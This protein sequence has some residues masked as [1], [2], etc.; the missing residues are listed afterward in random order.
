[1]LAGRMYAVILLALVAAPRDDFRTLMSGL[2]RQPSRADLERIARHPDAHLA[3]LAH[4]HKE[5][6]FVRERAISALGMFQTPEVAKELERLLHDRIPAVRGAAAAVLGRHFGPAF[7]DEVLAAL[8]PLLKD[9]NA[10]VR[11]QA[12]RG[13]S[14]VPKKEVIAEL[15]QR[16]AHERD[17]ALREIIFNRAIML[18]AAFK[19]QLIS[20]R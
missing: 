16:L 2:E 6:V 20:V 8:R 18:E 19:Q 15:T 1:M 3:E 10:T 17:P 7:P 14:Q 13:L 4:D 5:H 12:V 9:S 11:K